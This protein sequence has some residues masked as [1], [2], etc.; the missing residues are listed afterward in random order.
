M[1]GYTLFIGNQEFSSW[2]LRPYMALTATGQ[3]FKTVK[4]RLRQPQTKAEIRKFSASGKVP[5]L[6]TEAGE[7]FWDSLAICEILAER[8]PEAGLL[9]GDATARGLARSYAA[10]MH[11]GF[12]DV[13]D[14]LGMA[15]SKSQEMPELRPE[16]QAQM[17]RII[18][19]WESALERYGEEGFLFGRFSIADCMY[20]PVVSRFRTYGVKLPTASSAYAKRMWALPAMQDWLKG[21]EQEVADGQPI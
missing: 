1:A 19:A 11:S 16:T 13:R 18:E 15:Y 10:E 9:P 4:V 17:E 5:A 7:V 21:A 6:K 3:P 2:S 12:P 20:A 14:Q 8:H